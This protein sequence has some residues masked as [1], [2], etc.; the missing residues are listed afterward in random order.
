MGNPENC[1]NKYYFLCLFFPLLLKNSPTTM[2]NNQESHF[3]FEKIATHIS[4]PDKLGFYV[5]DDC[6]NVVLW[7][8]TAQEST[9]ITDE[10]ALGK[11]IL[12]LSPKNISTKERVLKEVLDRKKPLSLLELDDEN[13]A[14]I[15]KSIFPEKDHLFV[16]FRDVS[17]DLKVERELQSV[18]NLKKHVLNSFQE[19]IWAIDKDYKLLFGNDAYFQR[20]RES[21]GRDKPLG[22]SVLK[23]Q[24]I[25]DE[26]NSR[27]SMWKTAYDKALRGIS[28]K[29]VISYTLNEEKRFFQAD[30]NPIKS[31]SGED[32]EVIGVACSSRDITERRHHLLSIKEQNENLRQIAWAN[33]HKVRAPLANILGLTDLITHYE[34]DLSEIRKI[35]V[36]LRENAEAL[37]TVLKEVSEKTNNKKRS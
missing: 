18:R 12:H 19:A 35:C 25:E 6:L 26:N 32:K 30:L 2:E 24:L 3:S 20:M 17:N 15:R 4:T 22:E 10:E 31:S 23:D 13:N 28:N 11:N 1:L 5:L 7:S 27:R 29:I 16:M 9:G 36:F 21:T 8:K 34:D 33:S 14:W 37:D